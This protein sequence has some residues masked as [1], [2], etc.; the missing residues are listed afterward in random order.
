MIEGGMQG[1]LKESFRPPFGDFNA[2]QGQHPF[3]IV[4]QLPQASSNRAVAA[5]PENLLKTY[6]TRKWANRPA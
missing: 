3:D 4:G 1:R 2:I 6:L 5:A